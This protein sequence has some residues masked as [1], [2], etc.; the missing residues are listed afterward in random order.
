MTGALVVSACGGGGPVTSPSEPTTAESAG[1]S[2]APTEQ[3][4]LPEPETKTI[5]VG[6]SIT[7]PHQF[8]AKLAQMLGIYEK[9]GFDTVEVSSFEGDGKA[10]QALQAGQLDVAMVGVS[11]IISSQ[12]TDAPGVVLAVNAVVLTE[13]LISVPSV[14]TAEDLRGKQIAISTFGGTSHGE[15]LLAVEALGLT[16]EDVVITQVGA[17]DARIAALKGGSVAA[18]IVDAAL[19]KE[20]TDQGF[21]ILV[22]LEKEAVQWGR[23]ATAVR[24]DW[25]A[26][27]PN[28]ALVVVASILEAQ[29]LFWTQPDTVAE[30][31]AEFNQITLEKA[32]ALV[33]DFQRIGDRSMTWEDE[34]FENPKRVLAAVNPDM[35]SVPV[36]D[37]YDRSILAKLQEIGFYD[38][39]GSP[40]P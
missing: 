6:L 21:N 15:A 31:F 13:N 8:A 14:K 18:G 40:A 38:K 19:N 4:V 9:N 37:A 30:N 11:P 23:S 16:P 5:R 35:A 10:M 2:S 29:N 32:Q 7:Q 25:L 26:A 20:M 17:Q 12:T 39:I 33:E 34:S 1:P 3:G 24:K 22:D 27:N 28:A 36:S